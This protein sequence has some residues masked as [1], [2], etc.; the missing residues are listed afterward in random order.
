MKKTLLQTTSQQDCLVIGGGLTGLV[1]ATHLQSYGSNVTVLDKGRGLGGRLATRRLAH[2]QGGKVQLDYGAIFLT[3]KGNVFQS[4]LESWRKQGL[5][6]ITATAPEESRYYG[7]QGIRSITRDLGSNLDVQTQTKVVTLQTHHQGWTVKTEHGS[8]YEALNVILTAPLPQSLQLLEHSQLL[9]EDTPHL[10][11]LRAISYR[12]CLTVLALVSAPVF[13]GEK[14][15][16]QINGDILSA[17][18]YDAH[19]GTSPGAYAV[20]LQ[21]SAEWSQQFAE[22]QARERGAQALIAAAKE[23]LGEARVLDYQVHFWRYSTPQTQFEAPFFPL[24]GVEPNSVPSLYLAGDAFCSGDESIT[25]AESAF[26]SGLAVAEAISDSTF[27][28]STNFKNK[29]EQDNNS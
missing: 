9:T 8:S 10:E 12:S 7:V 24:T 23:Y 6:A 17:I 18:S 14:D 25:S 5:L 19:T 21:G 22:P 29:D 20:T 11:K 2:P 4:W 28:D 1:A 27:D 16:L 13:S 26:L 3:P 15:D